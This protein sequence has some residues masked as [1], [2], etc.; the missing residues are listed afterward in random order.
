LTLSILPPPLQLH[1]E[2]LGSSNVP[3]TA[4]TSPQ[5][6]AENAE[7]YETSEHIGNIIQ[8]T[9]L[10]LLRMSIHCT[11]IPLSTLLETDEILDKLA[12]ES[13]SNQALDPPSSV[14]QLSSHPDQD[15]TQTDDHPKQQV[16]LY[17]E[18]PLTNPSHR[19]THSFFKMNIIKPTTSYSFTIEDYISEKGD[20]IQTNSVNGESSSD[21]GH[22]CSAR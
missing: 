10:S 17:S 13:S 8:I 18:L 3:P 11:H 15:T 16:T 2:L 5:A 14:I 19:L 7:I 22:S 12:E 4:D 6:S 1:I 21:E 20:H 9:I